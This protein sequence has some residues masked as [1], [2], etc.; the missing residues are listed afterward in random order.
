MKKQ[1]KP[2]KWARVQNPIALAIEDA[3]YISVKT[4]NQFLTL[5]L[6]SIG[7][8][9]DNCFGRYE[10]DAMLSLLRVAEVMAK[11]GKGVEVLEVA[12]RAEVALAR[13]RMRYAQ[14]AQWTTEPDEVESLSELQQYHNLQRQA[15]PYGEYKKFAAKANNI[16]RTGGVKTC[17]EVLYEQNI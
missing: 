1:S 6:R 16:N 11:A 14:T 3:G 8:M 13:I 15:V 5:E 17:E 7:A 2:R 9:R 10:W 12:K 4:N